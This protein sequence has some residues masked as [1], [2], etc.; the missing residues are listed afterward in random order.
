MPIDNFEDTGD[1]VI[2]PAQTCFDITPDDGAELSLVTKAL[3]VGSGG[4]IAVQP[5]EGASLVTFRNVPSGATLDLRVTKVAATGTTAS[6]IIG[7][8]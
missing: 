1:S 8:A 3:Y 5:L 4:D 6:D 2:A 7:L